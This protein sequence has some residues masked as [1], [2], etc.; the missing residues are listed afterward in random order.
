MDDVLHRERLSGKEKR[1]HRAAFDDLPDAT[2]VALD[3]EAFAVHG[4]QLLRWTPRGYRDA[5]PRQR[6]SV[7][8][9]LTPPAI[10]RVL[11]AGYAPLWHRSADKFTAAR[12]AASPARPGSAAPRRRR[13]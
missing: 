4:R 7:A 2:Y 8:D 13:R 11:K 10:V 1:L 3:G 9:V 6:H 12:S 5:R